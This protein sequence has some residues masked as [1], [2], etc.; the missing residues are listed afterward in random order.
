VA[1]ISYNRVEML[2]RCLESLEKS[3]RRETLQLIVVDNGSTD[4][5]AQLESRFANVQF[6]KLPKNFGLTKAMNLGWRASDAPYIL[7]LH[8][9]TEVAPDAVVKLAAALDENSDAGAVCPLLVN[10]DGRPAPQLGVLPPDGEWEP[11]EESDVQVV[12]YPRGAALMMRIHLIQAVR[13]IDEHY[14]QFGA[15]ADLAAQIRRAGKKILLIPSAR[16]KHF[17]GGEYSAEERADFLMSRSVF[18]GKY[19][20]FAAGLKA[21]AAS[22]FGPLFGF[23][24]RELKYTI[25]GQKIDGTH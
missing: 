11:A 23:R 2:E 14:G 15:D 17:G 1:V 22:I 13:Q 5:S 19:Y 4:G 16:V 24:F 18:M 9:D 20:G 7:F 25:S 21:R 8:E 10:E 3:E 12:G 6:I